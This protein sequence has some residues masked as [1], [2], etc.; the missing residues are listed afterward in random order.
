MAAIPDGIHE[1]QRCGRSQ[2]F[3][4]MILHDNRLS[5]DTSRLAQ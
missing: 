3:T 1:T 4:E 5:R 2:P